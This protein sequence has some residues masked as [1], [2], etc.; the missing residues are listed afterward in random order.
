[1]SARRPTQANAQP[2]GPSVVKAMEV[3]MRS[4]YVLG[5]G[6]ALTWAAACSSN[7]AANE[8]SG[9]SEDGGVSSDGAGG[10]SSDGGPGPDGASA[11]YAGGDV[12]VSLGDVDGGG[13]DS[14]AVSGKVTIQ[15]VAATPSAIAKIEALVD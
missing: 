13:V 5:V 11:A 1:M 15:M 6:C 4:L 10:G 2:R 7:D 14:G 8:P 3:I 9:R 12:T